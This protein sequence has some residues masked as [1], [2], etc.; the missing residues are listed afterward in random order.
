MG[1]IRVSGVVRLG[2]TGGGRVGANRG[3]QELQD[4]RTSTGSGNKSH[5]CAG[6]PFGGDKQRSAARDTVL[7]LEI[8][9]NRLRRSSTER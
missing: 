9:S 6:E 3:M 8:R 4:A 2:D 5:F 1:S 7:R